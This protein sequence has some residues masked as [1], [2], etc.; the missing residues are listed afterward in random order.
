[1]PKS[2]EQAVQIV[3]DFFEVKGEFAGHRPEGMSGSAYP[4]VFARFVADLDAESQTQI[5]GVLLEY[6]LDGSHPFSQASAYVF[7]EMSLRGLREVV[8]PHVSDLLPDFR[9]SPSMISDEGKGKR[10]GH[11]LFCDGRDHHD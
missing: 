2:R 5:G 1:M 10:S 6:A 11:D 3:S 8:V 7:A 9:T 4:K